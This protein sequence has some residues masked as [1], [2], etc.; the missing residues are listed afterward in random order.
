MPLDDDLPMIVRVTQ[1]TRLRRLETVLG[2]DVRVGR[3]MDLCE[4]LLPMA[5][6]VGGA[7]CPLG[8]TC[9]VDARLRTW[10]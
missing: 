8:D 9:F 3:R 2:P 10:N 7:A 6:A 5:D 1:D 4:G